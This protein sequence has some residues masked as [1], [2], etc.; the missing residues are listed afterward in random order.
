MS[1]QLCLGNLN[2]FAITGVVHCKI[3]FVYPPSEYHTFDLLRYSD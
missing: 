2:I 1:S 3:D